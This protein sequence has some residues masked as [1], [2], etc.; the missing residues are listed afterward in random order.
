VSQEERSIFWEII[1]SVI[2]R[3]R[4]IW[5][6]VLFQNVSHIWRAVFWIWRKYFPSFS[7]YE[8]WQ[9]PTD[10][11]HRFTC[12]R[13]WPITVGGKENIARQISETVRNRTHVY[14]KFF[15]RMADTMTSQNIDISSW[16]TA[17]CTYTYIHKFGLDRRCIFSIL[18]AS[19]NYRLKKYCV[20]GNCE[21]V[22]VFN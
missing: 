15:L 2:I 12:F 8:Q 6:C 22:P 1:V 10:A 21:V 20:E 19:L 11:S 18:T 9:D 5:I 7:L 3:K 16:D 17:C 14:I 13:H 4:S